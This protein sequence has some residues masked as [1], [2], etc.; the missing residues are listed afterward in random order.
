MYNG[1][2]FYGD[3]RPNLAGNP[4]SG[5]SIDQVVNGTANYFDVSA[6][7][8]PGDEADGNSPRYLSNCRAPGIHNLDQGIEKTF[9]IRENMYV[10]VR[11]EF[12]NFLNTPRFAY[13]YAGYGSSYFGTI[14]S[15]SNSPRHG[16]FGARFVF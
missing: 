13:P 8:D 6:F 5:A 4:C 14:S 16:Q 11:A 7:S 9:R 10:E 2:I 1:R 15:T 12:F 3:Q